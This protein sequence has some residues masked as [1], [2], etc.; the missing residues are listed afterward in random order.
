MPDSLNAPIPRDNIA[1]FS[2]A[3]SMPMLSWFR[4]LD[5]PRPIP[6]FVVGSPIGFPNPSVET[7][8]PIS[9]ERSDEVE[10]GR[11]QGGRLG[12]FLISAGVF[13]VWFYLMLTV[14]AANGSVFQIAMITAI[15]FLAHVASVCLIAYGTSHQA[16]EG[17]ERQASHSA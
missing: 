5:T 3:G 15:P 16:G 17:H 8:W 7:A 4:P 9:E 12:A 13:V 6:A 14:A 10:K 1:R 2:E 11:Y